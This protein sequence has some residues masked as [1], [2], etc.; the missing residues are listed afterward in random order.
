ME[1]LK[2]INFIKNSYAHSPHTYTII[3]N[4]CELNLDAIKQELLGQEIKAL[5]LKKEKLFLP[6]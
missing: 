2:T 3:S 5:E 4:R 6:G 1:I